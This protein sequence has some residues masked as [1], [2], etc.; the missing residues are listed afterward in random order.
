MPT[1]LEEFDYREDP[2]RLIYLA[3]SIVDDVYDNKL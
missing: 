2:V 3:F 1:Q